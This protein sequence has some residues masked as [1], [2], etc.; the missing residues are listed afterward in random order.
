MRLAN[1]MSGSSVQAELQQDLRAIG[2]LPRWFASVQLVLFEAVLIPAYLHFED[3]LYLFV[4]LLPVM[5]FVLALRVGARLEGDALMV[6][7]F[8]RNYAFQLERVETFV[9]LPYQGIWSGGAP[10]HWLGLWQIDVEGVHYSWSRSLPA[11]M[12]SR[13]IATRLE[14]VLNSLVEAREATR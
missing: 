12:C 13:T 9:R 3:G 8:F 6:R 10:A 11:T 1:R 14:G 2:R 7:G 4:I 5:V